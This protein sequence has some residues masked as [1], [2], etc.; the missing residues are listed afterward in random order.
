MSVCSRVGSLT[1]A[2]EFSLMRASEILADPL[3]LLPTPDASGQIAFRSA[4]SLSLSLVLTAEPIRS[5]D[6][7]L[8]LSL[9]LSDRSVLRLRRSINGIVIFD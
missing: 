7:S 2:E 4:T 5:P 6:L 8:S 3:S 9:S 1:I